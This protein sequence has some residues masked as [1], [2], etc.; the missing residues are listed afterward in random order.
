MCIPRAT[1]QSVADL[2]LVF[3][4]IPFSSL[5]VFFFFFEI[6]YSLAWLKLVVYFWS[7]W[8]WG[9][10]ACTTAPFYAFCVLIFFLSSLYSDEL[11]NKSIT[12]LIEGN[13]SVPSLHL[14]VKFF[15]TARSFS[16][17]LACHLRFYTYCYHWFMV[18]ATLIP[19]TLNSLACCGVKDK[20]WWS[21]D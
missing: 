18:L 5:K 2:V 19:R 12:W 10:Q 8:V 7:S 9:S 1:L 13:H 11:T 15:H 6:S 20:L 17:A 21:W 3:R 14:S 16:E 4:E